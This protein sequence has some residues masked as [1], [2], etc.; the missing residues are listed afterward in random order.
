MASFWMLEIGIDI[1]LKIHCRKENA[2]HLVLT[3]EL[4][5]PLLDYLCIQW[6]PC[7]RIGLVE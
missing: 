6:R 3:P 7:A 1:S 5:N 2:I 4:F